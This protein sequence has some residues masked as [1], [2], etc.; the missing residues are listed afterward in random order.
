LR[1][2]HPSLCIANWDAGSSSAA[3]ANGEAANNNASA[4]GNPIFQRRI[5]SLL[6]ITGV[7]TWGAYTRQMSERINLK[8]NCRLTAQPLPPHICRLSVEQLAALIKGANRK[9]MP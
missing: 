8:R 6:Q 1:T 9:G 3:T 2:C 5:W 4:E 7:L